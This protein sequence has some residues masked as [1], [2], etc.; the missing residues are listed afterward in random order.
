MHASAAM[1]KFKTM[2]HLEI[3]MDELRELANRMKYAVTSKSINLYYS[4]N[5]ASK[6]FVIELETPI[7]GK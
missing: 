7:Q 2:Q 1:R 5:G 4:V 3:S 6:R